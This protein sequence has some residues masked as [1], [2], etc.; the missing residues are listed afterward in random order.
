MYNEVYNYTPET[1]TGY[2]FFC[3]SKKGFFFLPK[4]TKVLMGEEVWSQNGLDQE[5]QRVSSKGGELYISG[6]WAFKDLK[7]VTSRMK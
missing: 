1:N 2:F 6:H 3:S 5:A 7:I 4:E